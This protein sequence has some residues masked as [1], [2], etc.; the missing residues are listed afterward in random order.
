VCVFVC[1]RSYL[2]NYTSDLHQ[3]LCMLTMAVARSYSGGVVIIYVLPV[4][5]MTSYLL[6]SRS[7]ST[8]PTPAEAQCTRI[9]GLGYKLRA[10]IP[11]ASQRTHGTTF[12]ALKVAS[13]VATPG[14]ES[15]VYD[16]LVL[17]MCTFLLRNCSFWSK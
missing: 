6:V 5:R 15:A 14:A 4:L 16:C 12:R 2:R 7:C 17:H 10:V 11:V 3:F 8:S 1:P 9:L 13:Q